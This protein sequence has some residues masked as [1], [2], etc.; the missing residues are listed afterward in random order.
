MKW[1]HGFNNHFNI[2][3]DADGRWKFSDS[4][5]LLLQRNL[6]NEVTRP[7]PPNGTLLIPEHLIHT[8]IYEHFDKLDGNS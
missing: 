8:M 5:L 1:L 7:F 3:R 4:E 2:Q 6:L